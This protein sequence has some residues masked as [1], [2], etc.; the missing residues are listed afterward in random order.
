MGPQ[1]EEENTEDHRV[2]QRIAGHEED[3]IKVGRYTDE[4]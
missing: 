2:C 4:K 1:V 3:A